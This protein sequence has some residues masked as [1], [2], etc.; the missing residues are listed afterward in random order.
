MEGDQSFGEASS[1]LEELHREAERT[2]PKDK[3]R[4]RGQQLTEEGVDECDS[5]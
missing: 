2:D 1:I 5:G 3:Q 4:K